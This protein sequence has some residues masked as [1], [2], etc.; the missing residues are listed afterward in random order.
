[1][2]LSIFPNF[3][4][5]FFILISFSGSLNKVL[6][7][8]FF[9]FTFSGNPLGI[10]LNIS[11]NLVQ[12]AS[13]STQKIAKN[14]LIYLQKTKRISLICLRKLRNIYFQTN[15]RKLI[16]SVRHIGSVILNYS[17]PAKKSSSRPLKFPEDRISK[18]SIKWF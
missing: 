3:L 5:V 10:E 9:S 18:K 12:K 4:I 6:Q 15:Q 11:E 2:K 13:N 8:L 16:C 7:L 14:K 17:Q 1:M